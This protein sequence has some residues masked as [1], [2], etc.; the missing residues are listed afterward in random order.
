MKISTRKLARRTHL[1]PAQ[2]NS[3]SYFRFLNECGTKTR[4]GIIGRVVVHTRSNS[5][6]DHKPVTVE[7]LHIRTIPTA[8]T[9]TGG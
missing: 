7:T 1:H 4:R 3:H 2:T 6:S 5:P 9:P 8:T